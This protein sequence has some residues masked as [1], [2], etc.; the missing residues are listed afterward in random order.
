MILVTGGAGFIGSNLQA[1]LHQR[2]HRTVVADWLGTGSKWRNLAAHPP[3]QVVSPDRLDAWLATGPALS[4]VYHLGAIS[5]TTAA[6]G[7]LVWQTNVELPWRLHQ[8]CARTGTRF[9]YASSAATYGN[10]SSR[11]RRRPGRAGPPS[12]P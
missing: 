7:D 9:V 11:L 8:W 3:E 6:D 12:A 10:G 1:A 4:M 5:E 2:G